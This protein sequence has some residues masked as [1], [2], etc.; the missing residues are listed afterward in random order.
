MCPSVTALDPHT[1]P[2]THRTISTPTGVPALSQPSPD[3]IHLSLSPQNSSRPTH[4]PVP[5]QPAP[6][7]HNLF[8]TH[9]CPHTTFSRSTPIPSPDPEMS[10][11]PQNHLQ[12]HTCVLAPTQFSP[13]LHKHLCS[14]I[15]FSRPSHIPSKFSPYPH[16][17][18]CTLTTFS[19]ST[20]PYA[21]STL[22]RPHMAPPFPFP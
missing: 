14:H 21:H 16:T 2:Y 10:L 7:P 20:C 9:T 8:Q 17:C 11:Y 1:C 15:T 12:T 4:V 18:L 5:T 6:D 3:P 22:S 13:D 19:S